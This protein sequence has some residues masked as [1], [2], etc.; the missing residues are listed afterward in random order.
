MPRIYGVIVSEESP[1][2]PSSDAPDALAQFLAAVRRYPL[3]TAR[4]EQT[5]ARRIEQGDLAAKE[6]LITHNLKLVVSI[7][8]RYPPTASMT[9]LDLI[10]EG[11]LGLIRA[12]EKFD[13]RR[14]LKFSTYATPWISQAIQRGL[15][16]RGRTIRLPLAVEQMRRKITAVERRLAGELSRN[17]TAEEI[18]AAV[19]LRLARV[20]ELYDPPAVVT[21]LDR[22]VGDDEDANLSTILAADTAD[23]DER[24]YAALRRDE[25]RAAVA[26]I[27]E[28]DR[29]VLRLRYGLDDTDPRGYAAIGRELRLHPG[30]VRQLEERALDRL[31][32]RRE[33][34][35]LRAA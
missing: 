6:K 1:A 31:S 9:L 32:R 7:A 33:L 14:D 15:A 13:W 12:A 11:T 30:R 2:E 4:E 10:Q 16:S 29:S 3:L 26:T 35:T 18:A 22:S 19:G 8:R 24:L 20:I 34:E 23:I 21:S 28:P 17:P 27:A 5:L 25:V